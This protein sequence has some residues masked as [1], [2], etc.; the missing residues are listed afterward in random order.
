M[1]DGNDKDIGLP[2]DS[3]AATVGGDDDADADGV[4]IRYH[5]CRRR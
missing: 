5:C 2:V 1:A 4:N 3:A